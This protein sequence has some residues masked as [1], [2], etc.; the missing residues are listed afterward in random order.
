M[1]IAKLQFFFLL[2]NLLFS[3]NLLLNKLSPYELYFSL[4]V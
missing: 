2:L 3:Y 1:I 4:S